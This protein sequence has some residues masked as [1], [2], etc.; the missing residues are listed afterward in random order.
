MSDLDSVLREIVI[1]R[2]DGRTIGTDHAR[3][4]ASWYQSPGRDGIGFAQFASTGVLPTRRDMERAI[5]RELDEAGPTERRALAA[6]RFYVRN[7]RLRPEC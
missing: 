2:W 7:P 3:I 1:A 4:I 6:L 5:S